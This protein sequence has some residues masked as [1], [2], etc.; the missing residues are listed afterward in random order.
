[1]KS[2]E[3]INQI[4]KDNK[5]ELY[6]RYKVKEIGVFGSFV[7]GEQK[8][9]SDLDVLV[10]FEEVPGLLKFIELEEYLTKILGKK[11]DL[12]RR[13]AIRQELRDNILK[14]VVFV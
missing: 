1:M 3:E 4:L 10:E 13:R 11:V 12:V 7:R 9:R 2:L 8:K 6:R 5:E 14:E